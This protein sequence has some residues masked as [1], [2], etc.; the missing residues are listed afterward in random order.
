MCWIKKHFTSL[1]PLF[2]TLLI[3]PFTPWMDLEI[4]RYFYL[5]NPDPEKQFFSNAF[6]DAVFIYGPLPALLLSTLAAI[7]LI[8]SYCFSYLKKWRAP[9]LM[10]V[11]TMAIGAGILVHVLLKDHWGRP[12]PKQVIEFGGIQ[13]FR[14]YYEPNFFHQPQPSKSFPCG[15]CTMGFYFFAVALL[16]KRFKSQWLY[17]TGM[18]I[19]LIFGGIL[20]LTR[21]AQ[22]GHFFTDV[23]FS[24]LIMW[25]TALI[26]DD[27]VFNK[28][29]EMSH[30]RTD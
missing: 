2:L 1:W 4:S 25:Y 11:L 3:T 23:V 10:L 6:F 24:A 29:Q 13:P 22:G 19:A 27:F 30:E 18:A 17:Y 7:T 16:G 28:S 20:S 15:H 5:L 9:S 26:V 14:P 12:R 8:G 21:I